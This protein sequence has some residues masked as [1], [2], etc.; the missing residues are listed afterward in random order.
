MLVAINMS[1]KILLVPIQSTEI[2]SRST[3]LG[4]SKAVSTNS[5]AKK[6]FIERYAEGQNLQMS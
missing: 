3:F 6:R 4:I 5:Y 2:L 1:S